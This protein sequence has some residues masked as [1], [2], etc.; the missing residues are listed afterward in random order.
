MTVAQARAVGLN[1]GGAPQQTT[2]QTG[3]FQ[4]EQHESTGAKADG[5]VVKKDDGSVEVR[6]DEK[7][8]DFE[9]NGTHVLDRRIDGTRVGELQSVVGGGKL[10]TA[11]RVAGNLLTIGIH[12]KA[13]DPNNKDASLNPNSTL[14]TTATVRGDVSYNS[15]NAGNG[16]KGGAVIPAT[17]GVVY[18]A[19]V[20]LD[21]ARAH[22]NDIKMPNES[23]LRKLVD[24]S[25]RR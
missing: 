6:F 23:N 9:K 5:T 20:A 22:G 2:T 14:I 13:T 24:T 12:S 10:G 16:G 7:V 1:G 19:M 21:I 11:G 8:V 3:S 17:S 4:Q 25:G 15:D 18:D